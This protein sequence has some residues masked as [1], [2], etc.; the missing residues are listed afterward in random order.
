MKQK[1]IYK[2]RFV[3]AHAETL[4]FNKTA[5]I[6]VD[7]V[8]GV[9]YLSSTGGNGIGLTVLVDQNGRPLLY[10]PPKP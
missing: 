5:Y 6:L 3:I 1:H 9:Q 2:N 4:G 8:T 7:S 10:Q